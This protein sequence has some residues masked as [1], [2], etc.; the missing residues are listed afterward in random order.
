MTLSCKV[1]KKKFE[2]KEYR[3]KT[4]KYCSKKCYDIRNGHPIKY[5]C[6]KCG[7]EF[8]YPPNRPRRF[9]SHACANR[10]RHVD[11]TEPNKPNNFRRFWQRRGIINECEKCGYNEVK[12]ILGLHHID[13]NRN[14]NKR[15]NLLVVCPN[16]HSLIHRKHIPH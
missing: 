9:C 12:E 3:L 1:C 11:K 13:E 6:L 8:Y 10:M 5:N 15:E 7:K 4:A 2:V 16:C 14:N